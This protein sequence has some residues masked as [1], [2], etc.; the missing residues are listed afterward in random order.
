MQ[1]TVKLYFSISE[2]MVKYK[3]SHQFKHPVR[4]VKDRHGTK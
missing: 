2:L 3:I 4:I 1:I